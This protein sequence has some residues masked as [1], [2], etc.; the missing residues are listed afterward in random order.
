MNVQINKNS[1]NV[2]TPLCD[3]SKLEL[4]ANYRKVQ[5]KSCGAGTKILEKY[6]TNANGIYKYTKLLELHQFYMSCM[7]FLS[8]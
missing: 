1:V 3:L 7:H 8:L 4:R 5:I 2:D 6:T